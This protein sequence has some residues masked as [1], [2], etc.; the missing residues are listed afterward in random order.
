MPR[1][2]TITST[3]VR[4]HVVLHEILVS[5]RFHADMKGGTARALK[6]LEEYRKKEMLHISLEEKWLLPMARGAKEIGVA[7]KI[8]KQHSVV[9]RLLEAI[10]EA[11][12]QEL[13][14]H[15]PTTRLQNFMAE[16]LRL[17]ENMLY[18]EMDRRMRGAGAERLIRKL[19]VKL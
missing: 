12:D 19:D 5:L 9:P 15:V 16:H 8:R 17:E 7:S 14:V 10:D 11:I 1:K 2:E 18:P 6:E 4:Q 3:M 13:D